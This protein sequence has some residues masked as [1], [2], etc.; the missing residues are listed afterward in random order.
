MTDPQPLQTDGNK[1]FN[2]LPLVVVVIALFL[3]ISLWTNSYTETN[4]IQ[5]YC[6]VSD[7]TIGYLGKVLTKKEPA[8][9][10]ARRPYLIAAKLIFLIPQKSGESIDNYVARVKA[11]I[12]S[13]CR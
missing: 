2:P 7:E 4:S 3:L 12:D 6:G 9:E 8:G 11:T 5:R 1:G 10:E 13:Q